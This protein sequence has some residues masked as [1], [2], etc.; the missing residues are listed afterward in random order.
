[1][2]KSERTDYISVEE[3]K[4]IL[5]NYHIGKK[6]L[7]KLLG[8]GETTIIRYVEGDIPTREYSDKL[9]YIMLNPAYFNE[10]LEQNKESLTPVAYRKC[11]QAVK[12]RLLES[13]IRVVAQYTINRLNGHISLYELEMYLFCIQGFYLAME[14]KAMFEDDF[15]VN[16]E[17]MP[18]ETIYE[19]YCKRKI[20][21]MDL[22]KD[23]LTA[24]ETAFIN[25]IIDAMSWYGPV[26]LSVML[27]YQLMFVKPSRD[28]MDREI[29]AKDSILD[30]FKGIIEE[31]NIVSSSQIHEYFHQVY[32]KLL[33]AEWNI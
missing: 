8:W 2:D 24:Q 17:E 18:Y 16:I 21:T 32:K 6:P 33:Q 10:I 31:N 30:Y 19:D 1:M 27:R 22:K 25:D 3:I 20:T 12:E 13:K 15:I 9:K 28:S 7:A 29:I 26:M 11:S 4:Q 14:D 23:A 5:V